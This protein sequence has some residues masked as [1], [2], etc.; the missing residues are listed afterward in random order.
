MGRI[1]I[2]GIASFLGARALRRLAE[3]RGPEALLAIDIAA[4]PARLAGVRHVLLDLTLP[5]ADQRLLDVF[6][7]EEVDTVLHAAF[8]T[9]PRRDSGYAHELESIGTL[10]LVAAAAAAGVRH[11]V[12]RSFT[13][14]YGAG[15]RNPHLLGE[16][17]PVS[18]ADA[19]GWVRD[20]REAERHALDYA[21]RY[22]ELRV[23]ILRFAPLL[24]PGV[25]TFYTR[26]LERRVVSVLMGYD[27]LLQLLHPIDAV[28]ALDTALRKRVAGVFNIVPARAMALLTALHL[29]DKVVVPVPH[30]MAYALANLAW[31][32]GLGEAP[33]G[34]VDY[35]RYPFLADG[36]RARRDLGF[37]PRYDSHQALEAYLRYRFPHGETAPDGPVL[38]RPA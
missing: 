38:R 10:N 5:A 27:P 32:A 31:A 22:P 4:P 36:E 12:M 30:P 37:E 19:L 16:Q 6:R 7:E 18:G 15:G 34:F 1:A 17:H 11:L 21:R 14:L 2:T 28:D 8:L 9:N 25:H 13:A 35:A 20:K 23:T 29:A 26:I 33:A 24:G 3:V